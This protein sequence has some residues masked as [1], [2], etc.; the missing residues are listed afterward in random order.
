MHSN[1]GN[2]YRDARRD[3]QAFKEYHKAI[4]LDPRHQDAWYNLGIVCHSLGKP[5][6]AITAYDRALSINPGD[7]EA[8]HNKAIVLHE[9]QNLVAAIAGF[10]AAIQTRPDYAAAHH[11]LANA[12]DQ[13]GRHDEALGAYRAAIRNEPATLRFWTGLAQAMRATE[14]T[15]F[16]ANLKSLLIDCFAKDGIDYQ[17]LALP[18]LSLLKYDPSVG[19]AFTLPA[20]WADRDDAAIVLDDLGERELAIV[21]AV[22]DLAGRRLGLVDGEKDCVRQVFG[23]AMSDERESAIGQHDLTASVEDA[24]DH[25]PLPRYEL[26]GAVHVGVAEHGGAGMGLHDGLLG[27]RHQPGEALLFFRGD[28]GGILGHGD[29][30]AGGKEISGLDEAAVRGEPAN[31]DESVGLAHQRLGDMANSS[32]GGHDQVEAARPDGVVDRLAEVGIAVNMLDVVGGLR[33]FVRPPMKDRDAVA[34]IPKAVHDEGSCRP[35][36]SHDERA[37]HVVRPRDEGMGL[38]EIQSLSI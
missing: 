24:P 4:E 36:S 38:S 23:V 19:G 17:H 31:G 34:P 35:R 30:E 25:A 2:A 26:V 13:A 6:Q 10:Q 16:D 22:V 7:A 1:L 33:D 20:D 21:S 27:A 18:A 12:L 29:G 11:H 5:E 14:F 3:D 9:Q 28:E 15:G 37:H 8:L 32:V